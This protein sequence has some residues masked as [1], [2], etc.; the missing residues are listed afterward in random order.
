MLRKLNSLMRRFSYNHHATVWRAFRSHSVESCIAVTIGIGPRYYRLAAL[1]AQRCAWATD[2]PTFVITHSAMKD[3]PHIKSAHQIKFHL[4]DLF[5]E[6]ESILFFD[7]DAMFLRKQRFDS[8][9]GSPYFTSVL[10]AE[11][12]WSIEDSGLVGVPLT[13]YFN[14]GFFIASRRYH[15]PMFLRASQL[16]QIPVPSILR[17]QGFLNRARLELDVPLRS[18]PRKFNAVSFDPESD[19][20]TIIAHVSGVAWDS[21]KLLLLPPTHSDIKRANL[22]LPDRQHCARVICSPKGRL[23]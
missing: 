14:S 11:N 17:D 2:L 22:S 15:A 13:S 16:A 18:L 3:F 7:S 21:A 1:A 8:Y 20:D 19:K 10:D 9:F 12:K 5:P 6:A 4:F 23:P